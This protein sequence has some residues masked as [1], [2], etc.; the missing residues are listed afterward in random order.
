MLLA[1]RV[2][3][4]ITAT[5]FPHRMTLRG[6]ST[7]SALQCFILSYFPYHH[8]PVFFWNIFFVFIILFS[9]F[10]HFSQEWHYMRKL[11]SIVMILT[12]FF[13]LSSL[14]SAPIEVVLQQGF[15]AYSGCSDAYI[16]NISP[17]TNF[18]SDTILY[19]EYVGC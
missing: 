15:N 12:L 3:E 14:F 7:P 19:V 5:L 4:K 1:R 9:G 2:S 8:L 10:L 16:L 17:S 11:F 6:N 18:E 13:P